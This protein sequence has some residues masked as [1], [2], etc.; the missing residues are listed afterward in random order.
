MK[1]KAFLKRLLAMTLAVTIMFNSVPMGAFAAW[2]GNSVELKNE[3]AEQQT[4]SLNEILGKLSISGNVAVDTTYSFVDEAYGINVQ[5]PVTVTQ[6]ELYHVT[7]GETV[8]NSKDNAYETFTMPATDLVVYKGSADYDFT[9]DDAWLAEYNELAE[10]AKGRND[11]LTTADKELED[12]KKFAN[13][14]D[15]DVKVKEAAKS[16]TETALKAAE[17][18]L[19]KFTPEAKDALK[20]EVDNLRL[21]VSRLEAELKKTGGMFWYL[22]KD[23]IA[24]K[25]AL[26]LKEREYENWDTLKAT[27][28]SAKSTASE[29]DI[30]AAA[31]LKT[32]REDLAK[33]NEDLNK[34]QENATIKNGE[35]NTAKTNLSNYANTLTADNLT[36]TYNSYVVTDN[37]VAGTVEV[38]VY[39]LLT[40]DSA[41]DYTV[42]NADG[43]DKTNGFKVYADNSNTVIS[44]EKV[45]NHTV[46]IDGVD[47]TEID[48]TGTTYKYNVGALTA[49]KEIKI[50]YTEFGKSLINIAELAEGIESVVV[51]SN[52]TAVNDKDQ[53]YAGTELVVTVTAKDGYSVDKVYSNEGSELTAEGGVYKFTVDE[54]VASY[55]IS[56]T[57]TDNRSTVNV[58]KNDE[59]FFEGAIE[60]TGGVVNGNV[61]TELLPS[62]EVTVTIPVKENHRIT[63]ITVD[64]VENEVVD[65][66]NGT[67]KF[68]TAATKTEYTVK[69]TAESLY[70]T[71]VNNID[72]TYVDN[73]VIKYNDKDGAD[74]DLT[75]V[76]PNSTIYVAFNLK[77]AYG[78]TETEAPALV[79]DNATVTGANGE[80]TFTTTEKTAYQLALNTSAYKNTQSTLTLPAE[81]ANATVTVKV[82]GVKQTPE[83]NVVDGINLN[84]TV[85]IEVVPNDNYYVKDMVVDNGVATRVKVGDTSNVNGVWTYT[86]TAMDA[87]YVLSTTLAETIVVNNNDVVIDYYDMVA[88]DYDKVKGEIFAGFVVA[89]G[90]TATDVT[91]E[92]LAGTISIPEINLILVKIPAMDIPVWRDITKPVPEN[93]ELVEIA[94]DY[95]KEAATKLFPDYS[96]GATAEALIKGAVEKALESL[97]I[98][99]TFHSFGS[100]EEG[101][102]GTTETVRIKFAGNETY[103]EAQAE[104]KVEVQDLRTEVDVELNTEISVVYGS[105]TSDEEILAKLLEGKM[106]VNV[107][108]VALGDKYNAMLELTDTLVGKDVGT[109]EVTVK[110]ADTDYEYKD[111]TPATANVTITKADATVTMTEDNVVKYEN[112][113]KITRDF[114]FTIT[115]DVVIE[116]TVDHIPFVLGLDAINGELLAT[117]DLSK[118]ITSNDPLE[119]LAIDAAL[120]LIVGESGVR[121]I[122]LNELTTVAAEIIK[123]L[124][125]TDVET[126]ALGEVFATLTD[127]I[128]QAAETVD[129]TIK[130][131][132]GDGFIPKNHGA[133]VVGVVTTDSNYNTAYGVTYLVITADI[134][135]VNFVDETGSINNDRQFVYTEDDNGPIAPEMKAIALT[136]EGGDITATGTMKYYFAGVQSDGTPYASSE[137]PSHTGSYVA[138]AFFADEKLENVGM[139]VGALVIWPSDVAE[140]AVADKKVEDYNENNPQPV[141]IA[142]MITVMPAGT[143]AKVAVI[144]AAIDVAGDFSEDGVAALEGVI[145]ID[146]PEKADEILKNI[147]PEAY[148]DN[149]VDAQVFTGMLEKVKAAL[150]ENGIDGS[151]MDELIAAIGN[152]PSNA[153]LTFFNTY[154]GEI[155]EEALPKQIGA[156][157]VTAVV[158]DP[159]FVPEAGAGV[160]LITPELVEETLVWN[161]NDTNGVFTQPALDLV[162]MGASAT[163][164]EA[165]TATIKYLFVGLTKDGEIETVEADQTNIKE[166]A[167]GLRNGAYT[168]I[169]Y[170]WND[171]DATI[172]VAEP[173]TRQFVVVPQSVTIDFNADGADVD[174]EGVRHFV[175]TGSSIAMP[176]KVEKLDGSAVNMDCLTLTYVGVDAQG[177]E[178]NSTTAPTNS[179]VYAV[180]AMYKEYDVVNSASLKYAGFNVGMMVIEPAES[181]VKVENLTVECTCGCDDYTCP[182]NKVV[183]GMS[184][185]VLP[186]ITNTGKGADVL[187]NIIVVTDEAGNVNIILPESMYEGTTTLKGSEVTAAVEKIKAELGNLETDSAATAEEFI[188][189]LNEIKAALSK[190]RATP[191]EV[192]DELIAIIEEFGITNV[193]QAVEEL[194]IVLDEIVAALRETGVKSITINGA[195]PNKCGTYKVTAIV[196]GTNHHPAVSEE[197]TLVIKAPAHVHTG[198]EA[199]CTDLA[200]C[201]VCGEKYGEIDADNHLGGEANCQSGAICERDGCGKEYTD[202]DMSNHVGPEEVRNAR[203][204]Y[205]GDVYCKACGNFIR[206]GEYYTVTPPASGDSTPD[207]G[208]GSNIGFWMAS[209]LT[210]VA[211]LFVAFF[212]KKKREEIE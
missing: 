70:N 196:F 153:K 24:K 201:A 104:R 192:I 146:F 68:T 37:G 92:Y 84:S 36:A 27:A 123:A 31:E 163:I 166:V 127:L 82:D 138:T 81:I 26:E 117:V 193:A 42:E 72:T 167:K 54:T 25:R 199:T 93:E 64:G 144:T 43:G 57:A 212:A 202:K 130:L 206:Y 74:V 2:N 97:N 211:V 118:V 107:G 47:S 120:K 14:K 187:K 17:E 83:N 165:N 75:A 21:E 48:S 172:V 76:K 18:A 210:S 205:T 125:G 131:T 176:V 95:V 160:L 55:T 194:E 129:V 174:P 112:I 94:V 161:Y 184:E 189:A 182:N 102:I 183:C 110:M 11:E 8:Y 29:K 15:N 108:G 152:I 179:G 28:E 156:Y 162:D 195:K 181:N 154:N 178:Y 111:G 185:G 35:F 114:L 132:N 136:E 71:I 91:Y 140:V 41:K 1:N 159:N 50:I 135:S 73:V 96:M 180:T 22:N 87:D 126:G 66:E 33:A 52:G 56:A 186:T 142:D 5:V 175:Y 60:A 168:Q 49:D 157:L 169:A 207:T 89:E 109:Y 158:F 133:Y 145:N 16:A 77:P 90:I 188:A 85:T 38:N 44:F 12:A 151:M 164:N 208:D 137:E 88:G 124:T 155:D 203:E 67:V 62:T 78:Y 190:N 98:Q 200:V 6:D 171:V 39:N 147:V 20:T 19:A 65:L 101:N 141:E 197:A 9:V 149:G 63:E 40:V 113:S 116:D 30:E 34:K 121:E 100:V 128:A 59:T 106:G 177:N 204:G 103:V 198:G 209:A 4:T 105:Y 86:F 150:E 173:I 13:G 139:G 134:V 191:V 7:V 10:V 32:A 148:T 23:Y 53:I 79:V 115:P 61:I 143:S 58:V 122:P 46:S 51:E 119:Q 69:V 170:I 3:P 45:A 80:Y 99:E